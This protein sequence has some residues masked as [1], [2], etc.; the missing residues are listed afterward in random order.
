MKIAVDAH[1]IGRHLT[2]NEV[3]V[4]SLLR[5]FAALDT[6]SEFIAY[7]S[8]PGADSLAPPRF[9]KRRVSTNPY[10]RLGWD[11]TRRII[12]DAPDLLHV[13]YTAPVI[14]QVPVVATVHDVSFIEHPEYFPWWRRNQLRASVARTVRIAQRIITVSE[15]SRDAIIRAYRIPE[16]KVCVTPN[17]ASREFRVVSPGKALKAVQEQFGVDA[18]FV[19]SVGDLQPRKNHIG[20]IEAFAAMLKA[21]PQMKHHLILAGQDTWF[22]PRVRA[23]AADSGFRNRIHFTGFVSDADLV[24]L[25]NACEAFVFPSFYEGFGLPILEA[26]AC[27]RAVACSATSAMPEVADG[28]GLLFDPGNPSSIARA[29]TDILMDR[30]LKATLEARGLQRAG[31]FSWKKSAAATLAVYREALGLPAQAAVAS[32]ASPALQPLRHTRAQ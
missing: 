21:H 26:M 32:E 13:Q 12:A 4:R 3:Y 18:P 29:M 20:L 25:Y 30:D 1:A 10:V 22:T 11:L 6:E 2:G 9:R 16:E 28:A 31:H 24:N 17:A 5:E 15:F 27:G 23:A 8:E 14:N 19:L 7:V